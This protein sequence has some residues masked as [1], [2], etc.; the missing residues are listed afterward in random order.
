MAGII[1]SAGPL[2]TGDGTTFN[3][4]DLAGKANQYLEQVR[5]QAAQILAQAGKDA[6]NIRARAEQ[7]GKAAAQK[8]A[9]LIVEQ[10]IAHQMATRA[11][12]LEASDR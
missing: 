11:A 5:A 6:A 9:E 12:S 2:R 4:D 3:F 1:K 10:R 8:A 7:E